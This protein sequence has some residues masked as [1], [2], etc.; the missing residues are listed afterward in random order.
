MCVHQDQQDCRCKQCHKQTDDKRISLMK[1]GWDCC[2]SSYNVVTLKIWLF[3][4]PVTLIMLYLNAFT[5]LW[6]SDN[7]VTYACCSHPWSTASVIVLQLACA[8]NYFRNLGNM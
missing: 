1:A 6:K 4:E 5:T 3:S 7:I 8:L 2:K